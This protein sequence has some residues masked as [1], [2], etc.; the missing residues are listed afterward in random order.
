M[1]LLPALKTL[2]GFPYCILFCWVWLLSLGSLLFSEGKLG[3]GVSEQEGEVKLSWKEWRERSHWSRCTVWEKNLFLIIEIKDRERGRGRGREEGEG[4]GERRRESG[5]KRDWEREK[6]REREVLSHNCRALCFVYVVGSTLIFED[7][8]R[9]WEFFSPTVL[10]FICFYK[11]EC[12]C[13]IRF[14]SFKS[15]FLP[16]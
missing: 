2:F 9:Y 4:Q 12:T 1:T 10:Y 8:I 11:V 16:T 15:L 13:Q 3:R 7:N 5:W 6:E 14:Q